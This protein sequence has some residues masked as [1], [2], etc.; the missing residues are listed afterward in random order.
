[1]TLLGATTNSGIGFLIPIVFYLKLLKNKEEE[2]NGLFGLK[3]NNQ[4][5]NKCIK[6][7]CYITFVVVCICSCIEL[8][9][10]VVASTEWS[11]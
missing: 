10:Y 2:D 11:L 1:M 4:K 9:S 8:Y 5:S 7:I 6:I 3:E